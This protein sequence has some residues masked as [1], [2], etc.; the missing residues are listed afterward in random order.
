[1]APGDV[2]SV[3]SAPD[4]YYVDTGMYG[5]AEYGAVYIVDA[6]RPA[7]VDTGIGTHR[8]RVLAAIESVGLAVEDIE[9]IAPSHVHLDHAGGV[10]FLAEAAPDATVHVHE[11]GAPHLVDPERLVEGTKRAVRDQWEFYVQPRP[12][13]EDQVEPFAGG[14]R[15][16][17]GDRQLVVHHAPGHAP[18]QVV[19]E[20]PSAGW[21]HVADAAGI[22][23]PRRGAVRE[24][25][26]P[27]NFD[28][29]Q[30]LA[31]VETVRDLDPETLLYPHFGPVTEVD[32][33][34]D[35]YRET[36][37]GWV[38]AVEGRLEEVGDEETVI[39]HFVAE[40]DMEAIWGER[41]ARGET[42]MNVR[43]VLQYLQGSGGR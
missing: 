6:A 40:N 15:I 2:F 43:G 21:V 19:F 3:E 7:L 17:L 29:E 33:V 8:D 35:E 23:V 26:P 10:G 4:V 28:F 12:V 5:T 30:A 38:E 41:K 27:P 13:P 22:W 1:M 36:L 39:E 14:D 24:T 20:E 11:L 34:L 42:G 16:D 37:T 25:T 18:H 32:A 31:D 9:V